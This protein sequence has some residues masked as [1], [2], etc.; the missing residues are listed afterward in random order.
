M[1]YYFIKDIKSFANSKNQVLTYVHSNEK[2]CFSNKS[3]FMYNNVRQQRVLL[4]SMK[5]EKWSAEF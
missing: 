1:K 2:I 4:H 5:K 3:I